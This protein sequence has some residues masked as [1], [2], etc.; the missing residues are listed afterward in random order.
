MNSICV[1]EKLLLTLFLFFFLLCDDLFAVNLAEINK[2]SQYAKSIVLMDFDTKRVLYSKNPN[3]VF[4]PASLTK[5]VTIYTALIEAEKRNIKLKSIVPISDSASYYNAPPNSSLMFLEK[6]QI[7]N[8]EEILKGLSV[9]SGNDASIAI[10]EFVVGDL[11]SFVNLM[12]INAFNLGLFNMHFVEPSGYSNENKIT[13]LDMAFFAKSYVEKFK[14]MLNIHS[15]KYFVYP[16]SKNLGTTLSSKFLNLKQRNANL[17][18][19]DY[20]Y[21]DGLKTGYIKESGLNLVATALKGERRLIAV[22][23][24]VEKG[25]N[26]FGE[27][28]RALI[29]K[30]LFEYGFNEYSKFPLIV[31][32]KEKVYNGTVDTV[33]L[34]SKEPFY[35]VLTKDEF[36]KI[37]ISYTV[38]KLVAPLSGDMPVGRAMIFLE[39]EKVGDVALFSSEVDKLGFWQ[40]LYKSFVNFF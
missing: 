7:V 29:A 17:L 32:L 13:A 6:G 36:D 1:V 16:K 23:L 14:F 10:A 22:V 11:N 37:N 5:I 25:I 18:I 24:G 31:K 20:P 4:P 21:S 12:N 33:A 35:Y 27:K 8:F 2:L 40:G 28:M 15:L 3:L 9:S 26:R 38:D 19:D 34:F 30:N 39:N